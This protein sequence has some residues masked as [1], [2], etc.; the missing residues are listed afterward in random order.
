MWL[1]GFSVTWT[2]GFSLH[3]LNFM[4]LATL[5][6]MGLW[7]GG[8]LEQNIRDTMRPLW[9]SLPTLRPPHVLSLPPTASPGILNRGI[10]WLR[11]RQ[12]YQSVFWLLTRYFFPYLAPVGA[13]YLWVAVINRIIFGVAASA[14][15]VCQGTIDPKPVVRQERGRPFQTNSLCSSTGLFVFRGQRYRLQFR[16]PASQSWKDNSIP[17]GPQGVRAIDETLSMDIA[18]PLRR[19]V[20][21]PWFK[22]IARIGTKGSDEYSLDF[23]PAPHFIYDMSQYKCWNDTCSDPFSIP[24]PTPNDNV[25]QAEFVAQSSGELFIYVNDVVLPPPWTTL[26]YRNNTGSADVILEA[27]PPQH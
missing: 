7:Y 6:A 16:I 4:F 10:Q 20:G 22:P 27:A 8:V 2:E 11:T 25:V 18:V 9:Y 3:P 1:P 13:L 17:A 19:R 5:I 24:E 23:E 21:Q 15:I 26:L 14:G 12:T